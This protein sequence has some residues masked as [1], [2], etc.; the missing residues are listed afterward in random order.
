MSIASGVARQLRRASAHVA[1]RCSTALVLRAI[2]VVGDHLEALAHQVA[3]DRLP[4]AAGADDA[5]GS[6]RGAKTTHFSGL[7]AT[8]IAPPTGVRSVGC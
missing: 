6:N 5:D 2:D 7:S 8:K 3:D 1:P 4:D